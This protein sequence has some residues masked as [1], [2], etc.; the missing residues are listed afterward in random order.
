MDGL[1][2]TCDKPAVARAIATSS[3]VAAQVNRRYRTVTNVVDAGEVVVDGPRPA[4]PP[5]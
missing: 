5:P 2:V 1:G 4:G 3:W